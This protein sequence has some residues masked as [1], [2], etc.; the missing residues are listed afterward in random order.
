MD[1]LGFIDFIWAPSTWRRMSGPLAFTGALIGGLFGLLFAVAGPTMLAGADSWP[2][3][4]P[5]LAF[6]AIGLWLLG[7]VVVGVVA[8]LRANREPS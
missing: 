7:S 3:R 6:M 8:F 4:L 2:A 1:L 5:G